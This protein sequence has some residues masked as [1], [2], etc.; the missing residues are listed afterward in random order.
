MPLERQQ[1]EDK[2][3]SEGVAKTLAS[4]I[5]FET[6][7]ELNSWISSYKENQPKP[8][9]ALQDYTKEELEEIA[10]DPQFKGAKG[11]QGYLDAFRSKYSKEKNTNPT[12]GATGG[13]NEMLQKL[14]DQQKAL[15]DR[16][17]QKDKEAEKNAS[18]NKARKQL[19]KAE[20]AG[21]FQDVIIAKL[22]DDLSAE[23]IKKEIDAFDAERK[24]AGIGKPSSGKGGN[25]KPDFSFMKDFKA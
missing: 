12:P 6:E 1:I 9:K 13:D 10:K 24:K 25:N 16:L 19:D 15:Q 18:I 4:A 2:F 17:D 20:I 21:Y 11:L 23:N 14:L 7:D 3:T 5:S 22:G 8:Q